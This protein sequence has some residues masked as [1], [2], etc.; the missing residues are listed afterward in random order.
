[1]ELPPG[2]NRRQDRPPAF[3]TRVRFTPL[4][5][6][7]SLTDV[8]QLPPPAASA[9]QLEDL[10]REIL[11][12]LAPLE[13]AVKTMEL[14]I[15]S[16]DAAARRRGKEMDSSLAPELTLTRQRLEALSK[17]SPDAVQK[18]DL[19]QLGT[20]FTRELAVTHQRV[21]KLL[22]QSGDA[23]QHQDL[24]GIEERLAALGDRRAEELLD[25][26][27]RFEQ[28][29][30]GLQDHITRSNQRMTQL[31]Q[32]LREEYARRSSSIKRWTER[33]DVK[34]I[35]QRDLIKD[36]RADLNSRLES[37]L[38]LSERLSHNEAAIQGGQASLKEQVHR[39]DGILDVMNHAITH[40]KDE[41]PFR[42]L[43]R[44]VNEHR[45]M[46]TQLQGSFESRTTRFDN[47]MA[48]CAR[49]HA[50]RETV[51]PSPSAGDRS[52]SLT[53]ATA[54]IDLIRERLSDFLKKYLEASKKTAA[55][56]VTVRQLAN[57]PPSL[58]PLQEQF[59]IFCQNTDSSIAELQAFCNRL[60]HQLEEVSYARARDPLLASPDRDPFTTMN[61]IT[62]HGL[63]S[64][65]GTPPSV[66]SATGSPRS[67]S[68]TVA[69]AS[70][71][72]GL[73]AR[74]VSM[75]PNLGVYI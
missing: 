33:Q 26:H 52:A 53:Q 2:L 39:M 29:S 35:E 70:Q 19:E 45:A 21:D 17:Q 24:A 3:P 64:N 62:P 27:R 69:Q 72:Q 20:R 59:R 6:G 8:D 71:E 15:K 31:Q 49:L 22:A 48:E 34:M 25:T 65:P 61:G 11:G 32:E 63:S 37:F 5:P 58:L 55:E 9:G 60:T 42:A 67:H 73:H 54:D 18:R 43:A 16:E 40:G 44:H 23:V 10:R 46:L 56:L 14:S 13:S 38:S 12:R 30:S 68:S 1:M 74:Q 57:A 51:D 47:H 75:I 36:Q 4:S 41:G 7:P 50:A 28:Q 66:R